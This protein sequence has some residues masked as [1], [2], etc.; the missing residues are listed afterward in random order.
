MEMT[1]YRNRF[2][3]DRTVEAVQLTKDNGAEVFEWT[4]G[5]QFYGPGP[6]YAPDGLTVF[7]PDGRVK[8][9]WGDYVYRDQDT[10]RYWVTGPDAFVDSYEPADWTKR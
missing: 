4:P 7:T 10:E 1:V 2:N 3:H 5:K 8:A 6:D 9:N